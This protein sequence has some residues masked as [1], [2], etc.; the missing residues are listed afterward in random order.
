MQTEL[1]NQEAWAAI[2]DVKSVVRLLILIKDLQYNTSDRK[3]LIMATVE[4]DFNLYSC[5]Q[6]YKMTDK[7]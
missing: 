2:D 7:Y 6:G 4:A 3:R 1:K 5:A